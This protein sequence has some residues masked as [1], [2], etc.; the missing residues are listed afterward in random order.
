MKP[1]LLLEA[2]NKRRKVLDL[3]RIEEL[4]KETKVDEG[5][6]A[7]AGASFV[8]CQNHGAA[9]RV[10]KPNHLRGLFQGIS[11]DTKCVWIAG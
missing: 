6:V 8:H 4:T 3:P 9:F 11:D 1:A 5:L 2:V 7:G 10:R